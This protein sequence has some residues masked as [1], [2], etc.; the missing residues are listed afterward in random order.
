[1]RNLINIVSLLSETEYRGSHT[2][3]NHIDD[4]PLYD[5]TIN[6]IYPDDVYGSRGYRYAF[7]DRGGYKV[8]LEYRGRP[9]EEL[10]IYRAVPKTIENAMINRGDWVAIT[11]DYAYQHGESNLNNSFRIIQIKCFARDIFTSGDSLEEW[12]YDPRP[13]I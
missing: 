1:M 6:G 9:N 8:C 11:K 13:T 5:L 10:T 2:A 3:P 12:G 4:A 7:G